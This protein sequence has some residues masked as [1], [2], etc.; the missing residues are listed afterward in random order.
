MQ[1]KSFDTSLVQESNHWRVGPEHPPTP[2]NV[3]QDDVERLIEFSGELLSAIERQIHRIEDVLVF[4]GSQD[5][6]A[7]SSIAFKE[8]LRRCAQCLEVSLQDIALHIDALAE[9]HIINF[10][11]RDTAPA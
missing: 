5:D 8:R 3:P 4:A 7:Y 6:R 1:L 10:G 2:L 9:Q 11:L